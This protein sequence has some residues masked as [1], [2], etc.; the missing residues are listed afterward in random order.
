M[1]DIDEEE[2]DVGGA[3]E[4]IPDISDLDL[5]APCDDAAVRHRE[6]EIWHAP[7]Q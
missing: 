6:N 7:A 4:D 3:T 2:Q 1:V 5:N